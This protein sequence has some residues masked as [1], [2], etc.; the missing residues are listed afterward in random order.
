MDPL[1]PTAIVLAD[2]FT[3]A[4]EVAGLAHDAGWKVSLATD[5]AA[6]S[7]PANGEVLVIDLGSRDTGAVRERWTQA[8]H[9][10]AHNHRN[11]PLFVKID[12]ALRGRVDQILDALREN[13]LR[14]LVLPGNPRGGRVC[15]DGQLWIDGKPLHESPF[16]NDPGSPARTSDLRQ[17]L[18]P[19]NRLLGPEA[20][21]LIECESEAMLR[22]ALEEVPGLR[23]RTLVGSAE[24]F[25][26]WLNALSPHRSVG[27]IS[28]SSRSQRPDRPQRL[29]IAGSA[30]PRNAAWREKLVEQGQ[31]VFELSSPRLVDK[32]R[33]CLKR[34][35]DAYVFNREGAPL[36]TLAATAQLLL[37]G[38]NTPQLAL[39]VDGGN[40]AAAIA[41]KMDWERFSIQANYA[42]GV[43]GLHPTEARVAEFI[44]KPGSYA[45]PEA[46]LNAPAI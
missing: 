32:V 33:S 40:T 38:Q 17:L 3:G 1:R 30:H 37:E 16:A 36:E 21:S 44:V 7:S 28:E 23:N 42:P 25:S 11:T 15:K 35:H 41:R 18:D 6:F 2:D 14:G 27:T 34:G 9:V 39:C 5:T 45:W 31:D 19:R 26:G 12:S 22:R 43:V 4:A 13:G 20:F 29:H 10:L 8:L 46:I 24:A